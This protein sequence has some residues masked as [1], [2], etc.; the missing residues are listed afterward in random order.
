MQ[1]LHTYEIAQTQF[2]L[3]ICISHLTESAEDAPCVVWP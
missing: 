3:S 1:L 2:F